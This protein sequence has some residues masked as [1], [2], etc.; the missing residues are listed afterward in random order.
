M[1][2]SQLIFN[3]HMVP[4]ASKSMSPLGVLPC[5]K[6]YNK[7]DLISWAPSPQSSV[8]Y[9]ILAFN[10]CVFLILLPYRA[11]GKPWFVERN[12]TYM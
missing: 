1:L 7:A 9:L 12:S 11:F 10:S 6:T 4:Y 5:L 3:S 2:L 8:G